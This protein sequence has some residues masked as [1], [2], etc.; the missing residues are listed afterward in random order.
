MN[1]PLQKNRLKAI[2]RN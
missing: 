1:L 2:F